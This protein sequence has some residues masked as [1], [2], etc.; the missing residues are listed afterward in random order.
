MTWFKVDDNLTFH[1]KVIAA[2]NAA[3]GLWV[4]AGALCAH[5]LTD[6]FVAQSVARKLGSRTSIQQLISTGLWLEVEGGYRFHDWSDS[7]PSKE[8]IQEQRRS[9]RARVARWRERN[10]V[11]DED[12][13]AVSNG[14][15]NGV[16]N[17]APTRP[18]LYKKKT[19]SSSSARNTAR[20]PQRGTRIPDDFTVTEA[21]VEWAREKA[22]GVDGRRE[23][24]KFV[25]YWQ[26]ASGQSATKRDWIS[27]WRH[28][29]LGAL[30]R[31]PT[32]NGNG[33]TRQLEVVPDNWT[34]PAP[35]PELVDDPAGYR[36]WFAEQRAQHEK[37]RA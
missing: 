16:S 5:N 9:T 18:D 6:G 32:S 21:M 35:P 22:P 15:S 30:D 8:Q 11:T 3:M 37:E 20:T 31:Y 13:N 34:P 28:W 33:R 29:M 19:S 36:A 10:A 12:G 27:A 23:T 26:A 24:D 17:A 4:R 25:N 7:Q 1:P 2:G 14:V